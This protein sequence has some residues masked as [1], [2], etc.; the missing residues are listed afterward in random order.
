MLYAQKVTW[1]NQI[2]YDCYALW[3]TSA[4][5]IKSLLFFFA[6]PQSLH[7][8]PFRLIIIT[9]QEE[10]EKL[11]F[12]N[13]WDYL[14]SDQFIKNSAQR[15]FFTFI[16]SC[17]EIDGENKIRFKNVNVRPYRES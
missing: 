11:F 1:W 6:V 2:W 9:I 7:S 10:C 3:Q 8:F 12:T 5:K 17:K 14:A 16:F 13:C 4:I 15:K